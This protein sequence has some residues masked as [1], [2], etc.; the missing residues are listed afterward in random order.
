M[1]TYIYD[2]V[3]LIFQASIWVVL[4]QQLLQGLSKDLT[5]LPIGRLAR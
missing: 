4:S 5:A 1:G 2:V 3:V